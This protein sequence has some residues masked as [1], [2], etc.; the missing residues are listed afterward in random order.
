MDVSNQQPNRDKIEE[1]D[2]T[3]IGETKWPNIKSQ[4]LFEGLLLRKPRCN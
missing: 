3:K 2:I 4:I 1:M